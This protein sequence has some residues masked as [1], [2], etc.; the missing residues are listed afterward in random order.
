MTWTFFQSKFESHVMI[1]N[2]K[3]EIWSKRFYALFSTKIDITSPAMLNIIQHMERPHI[4]KKGFKGKLWKQRRTF[5]PNFNLFPPKDLL[6]NSF[7]LFIKFF[8]QELVEIHP[9]PKA[10]GKVYLQANKIFEQTSTEFEERINPKLCFF[11]LMMNMNLKIYHPVWVGGNPRVMRAIN[12]WWL[13]MK[14]AKITLMT[15]FAF[16]QLYLGA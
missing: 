10:R 9:S 15:W 3:D 5:Y 7:L 6:K 8:W 13:W 1:I 14:Y 16:D 12:S 2:H 11:L 4:S